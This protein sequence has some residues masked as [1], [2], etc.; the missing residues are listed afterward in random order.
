MYKICSIVRHQIM[1]VHQPE[2]SWEADLA[3]MESLIDENTAAILVNNPSNPCGSVYSKEH[4][5]EILKIAE[6]HKLPVIA[7]EIYGQIVF[8]GKTF[9]PMA[10][11]SQTGSTSFSHPLI[12]SS[13]SLCWWNSQIVSCSWLEIGMGYCPR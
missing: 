2:K 13:N 7:D 11:L 8:S 6:R 5:I 3:Q 4:L 1:I 10:S 12:I 9:Y